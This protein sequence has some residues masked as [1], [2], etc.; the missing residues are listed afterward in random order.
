MADDIYQILGSVIDL[1]ELPTRGDNEYVDTTEFWLDRKKNT[2]KVSSRKIAP[3]ERSAWF[4]E[5]TQGEGDK[6]KS[7]LA[8]FVWVEANAPEHHISLALSVQQ[9]VV[10]KFG[11]T[12]AHH[13]FKSN[14]SGVNAFPR[15]AKSHADRRS[16]A[17][18]FGPKRAAIWSQTVPKDATS[19][20]FIEGIFFLQAMPRGR[21]WTDGMPGGSAAQFQKLIER[22]PWAPEVVRSSAFPAYLNALVFSKEITQTVAERSAQIRSIESRT[23]FHEYQGRGEPF[24]PDEILHEVSARASGISTK[25]ASVTRKAQMTEKLLDFIDQM[26]EEDHYHF[27]S[28]RPDSQPPRGPGKHLLTKNVSVLKQRLE[29]QAAE[30]AYALKRV[31]TQSTVVSNSAACWR[32]GH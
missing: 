16:Y 22:A 17:F 9:H 5:R 15:V 28:Q 23:G 27:E 7:L 4:D 2:V 20:P 8:R 30:T 3:D 31:Q 21:T 18:C 29:M 32:N 6:T 25:L 1:W 11:L 19:E 12:L 13:Y 24:E 26:V 10:Q 14:L